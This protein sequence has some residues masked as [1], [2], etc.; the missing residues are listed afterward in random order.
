MEFEWDDDKAK[1]NLRK[2]GVSFPEASTA[3]ADPVAAIFADPDNSIDEDREI[4]V[5]HSERN[6]LLVI[7]FTERE[8]RLRIIRRLASPVQANAAIMK[9]T[10]WEGRI[11]SDEY[12][13]DYGEAKPNRFARSMKK[14][15]VS[16]CSTR[17][18]PRHSGNRGRHRSTG[19][20]RAILQA[21]P[22]S[23]PPCS[24]E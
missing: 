18:L 17:K 7:S 1:S 16:S 22:T 9:R 4:L 5:G 2:H 14:G 24:S 3:F 8:G 10:R 12:R 20:L 13:L 19:R 23:P 15:A 21:M 6:R 11:V